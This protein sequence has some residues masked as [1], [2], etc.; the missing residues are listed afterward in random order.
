MKKL[1]LLIFMLFFA[2]IILAQ[3]V[4]LN[5]PVKQAYEDILALKF[6]KAQKILSLERT[7]DPQN[8][9]VDYLENYIDFIRVFVSE[10][11]NFFQIANKKFPK[12]F[13]HISELPDSNPYKNLLLANMNLQWAFAR[14]K[15][16]Q[17]LRAAWEINKSYR[18]VISNHQRFPDFLPDEITLGALHVMIGLVPSQFQWMLKII[19]MKGSVGQGKA[20]IY[21]VLE[22]SNIDSKY[23]YLK[24]EALF[25]LGFLELNLSPNQ[26]ALNKLEVQLNRTDTNNMILK[27]L[28]VDILM[29]HGKNDEA[30]NIISQMGNQHNY[31]RFYYLDYLHGECLLRKLDLNAAFYFRNFVHHF[32]G[33]NYVKDAWRK[34]AWIDFLKGDTLGYFQAMDSV[35]VHGGKVV[36]ADKQAFLEAESEKLPNSDLLYVR[37]LFDGGYYARAKKILNNMKGEKLSPEVNL[38]RTYRYG[39]IADKEGQVQDAKIWY[40]RTLKEGQNSP[41]YFAANA[42]LMLGRMYESEDS[43]G[44]ARHYYQKCLNL[45]FDEYHNSIC[46]EA[47]ESLSRLQNK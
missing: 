37:L 23:A 11:F 25:F 45:N 39:R 32:K 2:R 19:S 5:T 7:R 24:D 9:Y 35:L 27:Y 17:Y 44:L 18:L 20:E 31:Y 16:G 46:G 1:F 42:S 22:T 38:E 28:K 14:I 13:Q 12:R 36:D 30:L 43:L 26:K 41:R 33:I 8:V 6:S 4:I 21:H 40:K 29:R 3:Q 10:D 34:L 15:F 47:R